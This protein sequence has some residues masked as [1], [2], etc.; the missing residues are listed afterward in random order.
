MWQIT[1]INWVGIITTILIS[2]TIILWFIYTNIHFMTKLFG[3]WWWSYHWVK[4]CIKDDKL[5]PELMKWAK[6]KNINKFRK[7]MR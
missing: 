1:L 3:E 2:T 7:M 4:H 6:T 5:Q